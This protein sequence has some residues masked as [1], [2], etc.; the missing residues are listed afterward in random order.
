MRDPDPRRDGAREGEATAL[1]QLAILPD[2]DP[3]PVP[4]VLLHG[5]MAMMCVEM[6]EGGAGGPEVQWYVLGE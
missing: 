2:W 3:A 1:L 6:A 4:D 5:A